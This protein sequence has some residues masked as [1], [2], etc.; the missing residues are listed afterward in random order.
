MSAIQPHEDTDISPDL[1]PTSSPPSPVTRGEADKPSETPEV[2]QVAQIF[3]ALSSWSGPLPSPDDFAAY[4]EAQPGTSERILKMVER[5]QLFQMLEW[6]LS[7]VLIAF[8]IAGSIWGPGM[9]ASPLA[10]GGLPLA[11][12]LAAAAVTGTRRFQRRPPSS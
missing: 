3:A 7:F 11:A 5:Q 1:D 6:V 8:G 4:N 2:E 12:G 9:G 10:V